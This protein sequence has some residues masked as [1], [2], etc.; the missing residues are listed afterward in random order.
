[1]TKGTGIL[2][3]IIAVFCVVGMS[4]CGQRQDSEEAKRD[5]KAEAEAVYGLCVSQDECYLCGG[6]REY[7][8]QNNVGIISLNSFYV[9][10]LEINQYEYGRLIEENTGCWTWQ[11]GAAPEGGFSAYA[12]L[13][14][15]RGKAMITLLFNGDCELDL[16]NTARHLCTEHLS[17]LADGLYGSAYGVGVVSFDTGKLEA[18]CTEIAGFSAGDY[19]VSCGLEDNV[20]NSGGMGMQLLV[21]YT[22]LR[23]G[24]YD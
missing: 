6:M 2:A 14:A 5:F 11:I 17:E 18:F 23:Y 4:G 9:M 19:Y 10:P 16:T 15:D 12:F 24:E 21:V 13:D 8:G 20:N 22:P 1:M 7:E 3:L